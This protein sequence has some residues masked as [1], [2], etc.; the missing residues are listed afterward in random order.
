M[1]LLVAFKSSTAWI[2]DLLSSEDGQ[3]LIEYALIVA[4]IASGVV[5]AMKGVSTQIQLAF[6][7]VSSDLSTT[8]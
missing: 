5:A 2:K 1:D 7:A 3:D 4:L 8:L 6:N